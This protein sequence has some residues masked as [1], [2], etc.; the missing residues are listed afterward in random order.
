ME[1][2]IFATGNKGKLREVKD[3][4]DDSGIEIMAPFELGKDI[5]VEETEA[6]F[7][8]NAFLK[9]EAIFNEFKLPV[10]ADD[11]GLEVEQLNGDPGVY[12]AR[13]A[14]KNCTFDDNNN[15]LIKELSSL[16]QPHKARFVSCAVFFDGENRLIATGY[17]YGIIIDEKRGTNGFGYDPIFVPDGFD[18][19]IS[20]M[21]FDQKNSISHRKVSFEKLKELLK[22]V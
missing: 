22:S 9:A 20:E 19:T 18:L 14:G 16:P 17:L 6:T 1:K 2:L 4:F 21:S 11:S 5:E 15:K 12:S 7:E 10:V 13:Y 3:I 8:G